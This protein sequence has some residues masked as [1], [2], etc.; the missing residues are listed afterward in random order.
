MGRL[1]L[2]GVRI[3]DLTWAGAGP[4]S[5]LLLGFLG[6]EV[7]KVE[8]AQRMDVSRGGFI[9]RA[10]RLV[11][12]NYTD[13]NLNKRSL[14]VN[15][16]LPGGVALLQE[17]ASVSDVVASSYRPGVMERLGLDY[18]SMRRH[19][20]D[21]IMVA[22]SSSGQT[23]P[24]AQF[25][26]LASIFSVLGGLGY[27][28]GYT[29]AGPAALSDS[30]DLR[31]GNATAFAVLAGLWRRRETGK[32]GFIDLA[33]RE[34][35][36]TYLGEEL[37]DYCLNGR[38]AERAGDDHPLMAPHGAYR[39]AGQDEWVSIAVA[40]DQEFASLCQ[41]MGER[42]L[43]GDPRFA[44][45]DV[46]RSNRGTLDEIVGRWTATLTPQEVTRRLQEAGV[47]A[48]P[49]YNAV[50]LAEDPHLEA[51]DAFLAVEQPD[52]GPIRI[53]GPAWRMS[54]SSE[55]PRR[56]A[57][58]LGED[59]RYVLGELLGYAEGRISALEDDGVLR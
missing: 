4:F 43:A 35:V 40:D 31:V 39:C 3:V 27:L 42:E 54:G 9:K 24:E 45:T 22:V 44:K 30:V 2:E 6:A 56:P 50:G 46:R 55:T 37:M 36:A 53:L 38:V 59:N 16:T 10:P 57:P 34:T 15:L 21:L 17:L 18:A 58:L 49:S 26:G 19:R 5:V 29:D 48:M 11:S 12:P 14:T 33:A 7:I 32:G 8:S 52:L 23:G 47:A 13:L 41:V 51:R 25:A 20:P 1:P 28:T